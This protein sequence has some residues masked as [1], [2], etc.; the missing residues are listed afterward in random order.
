MGGGGTIGKRK[1]SKQEIGWRELFSIHAQ[2]P[3][4]GG[5]Y[6]MELKE[7]VWA[8]DINVGTVSK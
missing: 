5:I 7:E 8:G 4:S 3:P 2:I 1:I 6:E